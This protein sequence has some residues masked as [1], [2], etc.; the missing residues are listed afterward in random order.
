MPPKYHQIARFSTP[1]HEYTILSP[2]QKKNVNAIFNN[3]NF[4][5]KIVG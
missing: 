2:K 5:I 1:L 3:R 4:E